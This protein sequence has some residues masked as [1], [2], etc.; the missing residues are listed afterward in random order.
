MNSRRTQEG[1]GRRDVPK[2][3]FF[4]SQENV[5]SRREASF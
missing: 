1:N 5:M 3:H 2:D 4:A